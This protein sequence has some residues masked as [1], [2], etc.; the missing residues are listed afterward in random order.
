MNSQCLSD[1]LGSHLSQTAILSATGTV[2]VFW[3]P[4]I[5]LPFFALQWGEN[6]NSLLRSKENSSYLGSPKCHKFAFKVDALWRGEEMRK[7]RLKNSHY[8]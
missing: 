4:G 3:H 8:C 5:P 2:S 6:R 1:Q 7:S